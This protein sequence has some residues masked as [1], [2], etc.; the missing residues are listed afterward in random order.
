MREQSELTLTTFITT[1]S[2]IKNEV[3]QQGSLCWRKWYE[4][5]AEPIIFYNANPLRLS[6]TI[7]RSP[8]ISVPVTASLRSTNNSFH[9]LSF[10]LN[11]TK[12]PLYMKM[13]GSMRIE[14]RCQNSGRQH[15]QQQN[16]L[17]TSVRRLPYQKF[18]KQCYGIRHHRDVNMRFGFCGD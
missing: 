16:I 3:A 9:A 7:A 14:W 13:I 5:R 10:K 8:A 11:D 18:G 15:A 17:L 12:S 1:L 6:M 4:V 2:K